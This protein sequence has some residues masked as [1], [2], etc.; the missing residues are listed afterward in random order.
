MA[1]GPSKSAID[2]FYKN[3]GYG[4]DP[5]KETPEQGRRRGARALA[6]AEQYALDHGWT[7]KWEDDPHGWDSLGDVDPAEVSEVLGV[8][9]YDEDGK[10]LGSLGGILMGKNH[11]HNQRDG[12]VFEAEVALEAMPSKRR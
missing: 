3:A 7:F 1:R 10:V 4:Y 5:K 9:L 12:R 6:T 11:A 2:F 8:V